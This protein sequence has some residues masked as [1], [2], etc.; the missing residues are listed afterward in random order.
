MNIP[1]RLIN[2][3][4]P[5]GRPATL[6]KELP[7]NHEDHDIDYLVC[8][9][10]GDELILLTKKSLGLFSAFVI[11][12]GRVVY[13]KKWINLFDEITSIEALTISVTE[14]QVFDHKAGNAL[15]PEHGLDAI[16]ASGW[17][18]E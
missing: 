1:V 18:V 13:I 12:E 11:I 6:V 17:R 9:S 14:F 3:F 7:Q 5:D 4:H 8:L 15:S 10:T 2:L 16:L